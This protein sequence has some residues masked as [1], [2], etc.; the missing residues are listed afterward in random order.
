VTGEDSLSE[1]GSLGQDGG[2]GLH[3]EEIRVGSEGDSSV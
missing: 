1:L 2:L 3:P